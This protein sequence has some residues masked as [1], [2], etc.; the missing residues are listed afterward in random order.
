MIRFLY[1]YK[2]LT[3]TAMTIFLVLVSIV[4]NLSGTGW[5]SLEMLASTI[6]LSVLAVSQK[7]RFVRLPPRWLDCVL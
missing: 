6:W 7:D 2:L 3:I 4:S 5:M 1:F